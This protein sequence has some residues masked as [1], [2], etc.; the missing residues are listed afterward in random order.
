MYQKRQGG[1]TRRTPVC[2]LNPIAPQQGGPDPASA[3]EVTP[4]GVIHMLAGLIV[5]PPR[6]HRLAHFGKWRHALVTK[7]ATRLASCMQGPLASRDDQTTRFS[8]LS[9]P[10]LQT[11]G[12]EDPLRATVGE[13]VAIRIADS[14]LHTSDA[15]GHLSTLEEPEQTAVLMS[16]P[17]ERIRAVSTSASSCSRSAGV[18]K[19][20]VRVSS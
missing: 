2:Y 17:V 3:P 6:L 14:T 8:G 12:T 19:K 9:M 18:F 13:V 10:T 5:R 4:D 7:L 15:C 11:W 1:A 20:S 16:G